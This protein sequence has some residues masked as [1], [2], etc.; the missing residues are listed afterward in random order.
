V[1]HRKKGEKGE[2]KAPEKAKQYPVERVAQGLSMIALTRCGKGCVFF[3]AS[4]S[5]GAND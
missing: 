1:F 3:I 5:G 4:D 2:E